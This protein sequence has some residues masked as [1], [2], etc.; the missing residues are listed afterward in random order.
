M[1]PIG[2]LTA[3]NVNSGEER[4]VIALFAAVHNALNHEQD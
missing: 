1:D 3:E 4:V 2:F